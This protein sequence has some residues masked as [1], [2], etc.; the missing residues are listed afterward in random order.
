MTFKPPRRSKLWT[1]NR[2]WSSAHYAAKTLPLLF[3]LLP[4]AADDV[5]DQLYREGRFPEAASAYQSLVRA[6][7]GS[8]EAWAGLGK[9]VLEMHNSEEAIPY[10]SRSLQLNPEQDD[11]KLALARALLEAGNT[12]A[13]V[14]LLE[15]LY[16]LHP[17]D[18]RVLRLLS[19]GLYRG[20]FYQKT[21]QLAD[22]LIAIHADD[23]ATRNFRAVSLAKVGQSS[24]AEVAC[25]GL[26]EQHPESLD[27]DV[28][29]TYVE[30]LY[31]EGRIDGAMPY[32]LK[33][34]EQQ[35]KHPIARYWK[36]RLLF[37]VGRLEE[38]AR[39]A[40]LSVSLAPDIPFA[41]NLLLEIYRKMGRAQDAQL[42]ADWLREYN[43]RLAGHGRL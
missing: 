10:L 31:E 6:D 30:I 38:A 7:P 43:D 12:G 29:L 14:G 5:A 26:M 2:L 21:L 17:G 36:A 23:P 28:T 19:E 13:A 4:A 9:S 20:G 27:L 3:L 34:V 18:A 25:K 8:A 37:G 1:R 35:P 39:E 33:L 16:E 42:Q 11:T 22:E 40:E 15:P 41:R 32:A 24:Q